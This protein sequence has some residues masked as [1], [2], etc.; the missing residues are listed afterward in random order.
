MAKVF[1]IEIENGVMEITEFENVQEITI[2]P[3]K[4]HYFF[5]LKA[6]FAMKITVNELIKKLHNELVWGKN[7]D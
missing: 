5:K 6:L 2:A 7:N 4:Q 3:K 1:I